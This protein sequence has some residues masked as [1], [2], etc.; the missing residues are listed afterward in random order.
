MVLRMVGRTASTT[1]VTRVGRR[2]PIVAVA[3]LVLRWWR[4]NSMHADRTTVRIR[5]GESLTI[6]DRSR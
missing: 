2:Y 4:R 6:S 3:L 1:F 5:P